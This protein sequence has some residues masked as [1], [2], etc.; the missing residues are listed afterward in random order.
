MKDKHGI[1]VKRKQPSSWTEE[2][3]TSVGEGLSVL[4]P[5]VE[6]EDFVKRC[7]AAVPERKPKDGV[8]DTRR[9]D[10]IRALRRMAEKKRLPFKVV[11]DY[12]V[13]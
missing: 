2:L 10:I 3:I 6:Q 7:I 1:L 5:R 11:G 4:L 13:F 12:F 8:R 9:Q